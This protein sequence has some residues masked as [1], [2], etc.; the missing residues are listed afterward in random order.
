MIGQKQ[1][2]NSFIKKNISKNINVKLDQKNKSP[3]ILKKRFIEHLSNNKIL[4]VYKINDNPLEK[5]DELNY[6]NLL[7]KK[8]KNM[9]WL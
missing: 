5:Q 9:I 7:I 8:L 4:G 6:R 3:T 1:E 2:D